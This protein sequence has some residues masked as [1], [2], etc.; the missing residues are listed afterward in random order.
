MSTTVRP[1][2]QSAD[3]AVNRASTQEMERRLVAQGILSRRVPRAIP[4]RWFETM[5][6]AGLRRRTFCL[7]FAMDPIPTGRERIRAILP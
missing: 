1:V 3:V 4:M 2:T 5:R 6:A 7:Q